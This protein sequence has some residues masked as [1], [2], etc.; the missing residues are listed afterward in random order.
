[1]ADLSATPFVPWQSNPKKSLS[2]ADEVKEHGWEGS[3][4]GKTQKI[5]RRRGTINEKQKK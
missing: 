5:A 1:M 2:T 4:A 3:P